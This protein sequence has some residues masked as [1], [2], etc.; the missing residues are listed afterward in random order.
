MDF[1]KQRAISACGTCGHQEWEHLGAVDEAES[2]DVLA[3]LGGACRHFTVSDAAFTYQRHLAIAQQ[4]S[5]RRR[6]G[7]RCSRCGNRG[8]EKGNCVL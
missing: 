6:N 8:H 4:R 7:P 2:L 1:A 5:G 3:A